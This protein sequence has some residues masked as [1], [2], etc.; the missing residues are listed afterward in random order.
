MLRDKVNK[1]LD[2][3]ASIFNK[4]NK[5]PKKEKPKVEHTHYDISA[6]QGLSS[7]QVQER[8]LAHET[9]K[10][11]STTDR[12]YAKIIFNNFFTFYNTICRNLITNP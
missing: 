4:K 8:I 2:D 3:V 6:E 12:S 9:N 5:K 7:E 10:V 11:K 1:C